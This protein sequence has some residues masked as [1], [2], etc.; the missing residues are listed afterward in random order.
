M[1]RAVV[2]LAVLAVAFAANAKPR[3]V[4]ER[5]FFD[6]VKQYNLQ[7]SSGEEFSARIQVF[8]NNIDYIEAHNQGNHTYK[9]GINQFA[10]LTFEEFK[11]AV[12]LGAT[13]PT[14]LRRNPSKIHQAPADPKSLP[15]SVDWTVAGAVTEVKNQGSCGSCWA[16][17]AIGSLESAYYLKTGKLKEFSEQQIVSCDTGDYGCNG[18]WMDTAF[19]Y[20]QSAGG[21]A[22][23]IDY[24]YTSSPGT[25]AACLSS[26]TVDSDVTPSGYTDVA[27][28]SLTALQS[29]V[30]QQPVS[31]AIQA[32]Q[33]SFQF[34]SS[35]VFTG[36]C[37]NNLDHGVLLTGYGT[38]DGTDYWKV[39][40]SWGS[41]WGQDGYILI[42]RSSADKCGV[43][44][45]P[46]YPTL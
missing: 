29:A 6:Y 39:K 35:G 11:R 3:E 25:N 2:V 28:G 21:L 38:Q 36:R 32:N 14:N 42:E 43:L 22:S 30:S 26:F 7:F 40:N 12:N 16:F 9:M 10:H 37:G 27:T 18:G 19:E 33:L 13:R 45:A 44:D 4:Y 31:I 5:I 24:P 8:A 23:E 41:S 15:D 34:Y 46:S 1:F 17:S 20:V